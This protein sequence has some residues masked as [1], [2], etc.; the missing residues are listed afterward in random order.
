MNIFATSDCPVESARAL[1]DILVIKMIVESAQLLSTAH[2]ELSGTVVGYKPTHKNHPCAIWARL[3]D[4]N[5][6]WLHEHMKAL[7]DEYTYRTGKVHKSRE[8]LGV[9]SKPPQ[10]IQKKV[11]NITFM[12][13]PDDYKKTICVHKNYRAYLKGKFV[14]WRLRTDKRPIIAKWSRRPKPTWLT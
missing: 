6:T 4:G 2:Y 1:P 11:V 5:Y 9:L 8:V 12:C 10:K 14:A 7:C 3:S 13:M